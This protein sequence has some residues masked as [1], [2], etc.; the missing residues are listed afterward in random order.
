MTSNANLERSSPQPLPSLPASPTEEEDLGRAAAW[1]GYTDDRDADISHGGDPASQRKGKG[2]EADPALE[3]SY[4]DGGTDEDLRGMDEGGEVEGYP[5]MSEDATE[6]RR[7][8]ENLRRWEIAERQRR[9]AA[10]ESSHNSQPKSSAVAEGGWRAS[11]LWPRRASRVPTDGVG[12]HRALRTSEDAVPLDDIEGS[13]S[14]SGPPSPSPT[15]A[16]GYA[17][18][19]TRAENP[20]ADPAGSSSSLFVNAQPSSSPIEPS[21]STAETSALNPS[22]SGVSFSSKARLHPPAPLGL[23]PPRTPPPPIDSPFSIRPPDPIRTPDTSHA[24]GPHEDE[25]PPVRWWTE[26]LCGCSEGPDRGGEAQ[27]ARTN[28]L[29]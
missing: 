10:R 4:A 6:T 29:E 2:R 14:P 3:A 8:E 17:S 7:I 20:F 11:S 23:P 16:P 19:S 5:P 25:G 24:A 12:T 9:K 1:G 13:P 26:W 21:D 22:D 18:K 27:A 28:P 15:P